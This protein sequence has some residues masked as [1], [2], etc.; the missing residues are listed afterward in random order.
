MHF[1]LSDPYRQRESVVH[2]FDPRL[3]VVATLFIILAIGLTPEGRWWAFL[4]QYLFLVLAAVV[5]RLGL[6]YTFRRS[7]IALPFM[8]AALAVPFTVAGTEIYRLPGLDWSISETGLVRFLSILLRAWIAVQAAILLSA[9]TRVSDLFW[10]LG[11]LRL[12]KALAATISF[13]YRYLFLLADEAS[14]MLRARA[15]RSPKIS[16]SPKPG[17]AWQGKVAGGMVGNLFLRSIER[18]ERV[19]AAML[20]RGYDG[21]IRTM[22]KFRM[23]NT[24]WMALILVLL[25][26]SGVQLLAYLS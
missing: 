7:F 6:F 24:D 12:P 2:H 23:Q 5:A 16:G 26:L 18:S 4:V 20:S 10:A 14:R 17:L 8:L 19:Y 21:E 13:M 11:A 9:S 22:Q 3:K 1:D 25:F 15:S